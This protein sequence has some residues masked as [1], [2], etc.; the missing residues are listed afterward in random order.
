MPKHHYQHYSNQVVLMHSVITAVMRIWMDICII[1][2]TLMTKYS[3]VPYVD[4]NVGLL[5]D[6][7]LDLDF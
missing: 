4:L 1:A 2:L 7:E 5:R 6:V 3:K